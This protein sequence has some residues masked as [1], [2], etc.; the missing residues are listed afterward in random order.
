MH[1]IG[2][3]ETPQDL[4]VMDVTTATNNISDIIDTLIIPGTIEGHLKGPSSNAQDPQF[5]P[6]NDNN[7]N[8]QP[9][10]ARMAWVTQEEYDH[11]CVRKTWNYCDEMAH[12]SRKCSK[13][14]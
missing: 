13:C 6:L 12:Y 7:I 11:Q 8:V 14:K 4:G 9:S 5:H 10:V 1:I 3:R 2:A